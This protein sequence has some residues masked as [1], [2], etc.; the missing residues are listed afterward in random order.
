MYRKKL[1]NAPLREVIFEIFWKL[2][3][4]NQGFLSDP[5]FEFAQG[6]FSSKISKEFPLHKRLFPE[7]A[8]LD[9]YY[10]P[11]HQFWKGELIWP[12]VQLG[13]GILTVNDTELNYQWE[14]NYRNLILDTIGVLKASYIR[15]PLEIHKIKLQYIDAVQYSLTNTTFSDFIS[16]NLNTELSNNFVIPGTQEGT[17]IIQS[18]KQDDGSILNISIQSAK[19]GQGAIEVPSIVWTYSMERNVR[20]SDF[21]VQKWLDSSHDIC[22]D[23][24]RKMLNPSFYASFDN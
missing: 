9:I 6:I 15:H 13:K 22:S 8:P 1:K 10:K 4:N 18:F 19:E 24:F 7:S 20:N 23:L 17:K 2:P 21:N 16:H 11:I 12:V 5:G 14:D 3:V